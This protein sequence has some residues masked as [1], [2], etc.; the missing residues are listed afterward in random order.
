MEAAMT[1]KT[2]AT[3]MPGQ[4]VAAVARPLAER[5]LGGLDRLVT[6]I[7]LATVAVM[8]GV[9]S[10]QVALRYGLNLSLDWADEVGRLAFV[11]SIFMAIP[12]GVR[13]GSHIGI[14]ILVDKLPPGWQSAFRRAAAALCAALMLAI[15]W[16]SLGVAREQ[17]DELMA[18]V[19]W[20]VGWFIV[21]VGLGALLS[22]LH[23][24]WITIAGAPLPALGGAE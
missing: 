22:A 3:E 9:V 11:W 16:A 14:N 5:L 4:P 24:V 23:L 19:D 15:A 12:L 7:L 20:S 6:A 18:T 2:N 1:T 17:W 10:A 13:Q 8:V 21:P